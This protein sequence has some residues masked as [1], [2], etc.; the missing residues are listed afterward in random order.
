MWSFYLYVCTTSIVVVNYIIPW[1]TGNIVTVVTVTNHCVR[2]IYPIPRGWQGPP[3]QI[4]SERMFVAMQH[5][6]VRFLLTLFLFNINDSIAPLLRLLGR[7]GRSLTWLLQDVNV[8]VTRVS[9]WFA[10]FG[11]LAWALLHLLCV[12]ALCKIWWRRWW[13]RRWWRRWQWR[14]PWL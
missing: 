10:S 4:S 8:I 1:F 6:L 5:S 14:A 3:I 7:V 13:W 12:V 2:G 11:T 9:A